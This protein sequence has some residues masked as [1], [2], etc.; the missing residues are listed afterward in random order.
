[1]FYAHSA[2]RK[3]HVQWQTL[4]AHL[5]G[6]AE[7]A[8]RFGAVFGAEKAARLAGLLHDL[9]KYN[10]DFQAYIKGAK[11]RVDHATAGAAIV[12]QMAGGED[13]IVADLLA[14]HRRPSFRS[15]G[16]AG[17]RLLHIGR[18]SAGFRSRFAGPRLDCGRRDGSRS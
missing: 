14:C 4:S 13:R 8:A 10:P 2:E 18:A 3:S 16:Q 15:A 11:L 9:G 6:V 12:L 5:L 1:M 17:R 7:L